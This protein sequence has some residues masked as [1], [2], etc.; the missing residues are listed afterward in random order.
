MGLI[1]GFFKGMYL[2]VRVVLIAAAVA[3]VG[4]FLQTL[5]DFDWTSALGAWAVPIGIIAAWAVSYWKKE[6]PPTG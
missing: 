5:A 4:G 2:K 6:H 3:A 1:I